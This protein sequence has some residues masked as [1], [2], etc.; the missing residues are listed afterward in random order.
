MRNTIIATI[1]VAFLAV[2]AGSAVGQPV[3]F[4]HVGILGVGLV[5][6]HILRVDIATSG[7]DPHG[8]DSL[9]VILD[10]WLGDTQAHGSLLATYL[11]P[12]FSMDIDFPVGGVRVGA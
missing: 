10:V 3:T 2:P 12:R 11:P 8:T 6:G 5:N 4:P 1:V 9:D 7:L